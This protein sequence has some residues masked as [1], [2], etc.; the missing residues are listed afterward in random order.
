[1]ILDWIH[2]ESCAGNVLILTLDPSVGKSW[3]NWAP[4]API[5]VTWAVPCALPMLSPRTE[6]ERRAGSKVNFMLKGASLV[7]VQWSG[8]STSAM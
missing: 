4:A 8:S 5:K 6:V 1:M 3:V 2:N 7:K